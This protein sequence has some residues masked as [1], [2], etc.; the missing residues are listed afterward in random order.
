MVRSLRQIW[1]HLTSAISKRTGSADRPGLQPAAG[2]QEKAFVDRM[3]R[4]VMR[5][6]NHP[7]V[8]MW[9]P[10]N[11]AGANHEAMAAG[12]AARSFPVH[13]EGDRALSRTCS[14]A[15]IERA[16]N[17]QDKRGRA[18]G[19]RLGRWTVE[20]WGGRPAFGG[21]AYAC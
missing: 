20:K 14:A 9:S 8:I 16:R 5:D 3:E 4:M 12:Q 11:P 21:E 13:Y 1:H 19:D 17:S 15:C 18:A 7:C 2:L 10:T 6:R